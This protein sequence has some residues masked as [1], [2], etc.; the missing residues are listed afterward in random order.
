[1]SRVEQR[2]RDRLLN[3]L[4]RWHERRGELDQARACYL[5]STSHPARERLSRLLHRLGDHEGVATLLAAMRADPWA[6]EEQDFAG[7]FPG[8]RRSRP[9]M[10]S[11]CRLHAATPPAIEQH[12]LTLLTAG[13]GQGWH[14][15]N[16]LPLGLAGLLFW[17]EVFAPVAGAFSHP[18]QPAPRD[19]FWPDFAR[20]RQGLLSRRRDELARPGAVGQRLRAVSRCKRGITNALVHWQA[21]TPSLIETL[22]D[23]VPHEALMRLADYT[24]GN[25][26]RCRN[27]FPDLLVVYGPGAWELV[28][29]KGPNDQ[30]QP[31][32]RVWLATLEAL[33]LPARVLKFKS[34]C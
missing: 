27:G 20:V 1:M 24:I 12:A 16:L 31:A 32:Q 7:R 8:R 23:N 15:E 29:V 22:L 14:L 33:S 9:P 17:D 34:A 26:H 25:L 13:G 19:L 18:L 21:L 10:V 2:T 6:P 11:V 3:D 28:E 30:L 5:E 4:G